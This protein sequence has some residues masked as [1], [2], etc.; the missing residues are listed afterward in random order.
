VSENDPP[1]GGLTRR[2][3]AEQRPDVLQVPR[4]R[5]EAT[6]LAEA[7]ATGEYA[8]GAILWLA[9]QI[10]GPGGIGSASL[11]GIIGDSSHTYGY[12]RCRN[13]LP[14][15]DY[16][17]V[18]AKDK[19]GDGWAAAALDISYSDSDMKLVTGRLMKAMKAR[20]PRISPYVR[21]FFGTLNGTTVTGWDSHSN[22]YTSS[23]DSHLWHVHFSFYREY[24]NN[25]TI[26]AGIRDVNLGH[27][28]DDDMPIRTSVGITRA[29]QKITPDRWN[30]IDWDR[31]WEGP[32]NAH[33]PG[34]PG[35]VSQA[36]SDADF[37]ASFW[38]EGVRP[39]DEYQARFVVAE[40]DAKKSTTKPDPWTEVRADGVCGSGR[41]LVLA[42]MSKGLTRTHHTYVEVIV[43]PRGENTDRDITVISGRWT[44]RQDR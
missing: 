15:N 26:M 3:A 42:T 32:T 9:D 10:T 30:R 39:G 40:W 5:E 19:L 4:D 17:V 11:S 21:E 23:D 14:G 31:D 29:G 12:H 20:D 28:G 8:P 44:I 7:E 38:L 22:G 6:S 16:S 27:K 35:Y 1:R 18:L 13:V 41:Q 25:Q 2:E 24:V 33:A 37:D 43:W 36:A 34:L